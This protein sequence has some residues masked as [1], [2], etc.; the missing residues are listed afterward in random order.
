MTTDTIRV[1]RTRDYGDV[2][3]V[4]THPR[5]WKAWSGG[6]EVTD[7]IPP[8]PEREYW[9]IASDA[10]GPF[11]A[12]RFEHR[13]TVAVEGHFG[14][15]PRAWGLK[16]FTAAQAAHEWLFTATPYRKIIGFTPACNRLALRFCARLGYEAEGLIRG[17]CETG[18]MVVFGLTE[19]DWRS[20]NGR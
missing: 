5:V 2:L 9:L 16:A 10:Y 11:G 4:V 20:R 17:A 3:A 14:F 7:D 6:G 8:V 13:N 15:Q 1:E 18:D 19:A 12:I